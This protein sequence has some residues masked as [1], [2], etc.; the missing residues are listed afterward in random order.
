M[1]NELHP[2]KLKRDLESD[3]FGNIIVLFDSV[4]ST[5]SAGTMLA[6]RG[7]P[8]GTV[9]TTVEQVDG[10]GRMER[11]WFSSSADSLIFTVILKPKKLPIGLTSLMAYSIMETFDDFCEGTMMK[12]PNDIFYKDRKIGGI[13]AEGNKDYMV[14]G[15]GLNINQEEKDFPDE[16]LPIA[17]SIRIVKG[18][19]FDR[20]ILLRRIIEVFEKNYK[21]WESNGFSV[22]KEAAEARLLYINTDVIITNGKVHKSGEVAGIT[23]EGY[24]LLRCGD[25]TVVFSSGDLSLRKKK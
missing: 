5:N 23:E 3:R 16:L 13:L 8:E 25:E 1:L 6:E 11:K 7:F 10:R 12:W 2:A 21:R 18:T 4:N 14:I 24:L 17:S 15:A 9:V 20:G 19:R 22:F